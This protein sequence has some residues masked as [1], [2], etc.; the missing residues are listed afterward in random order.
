MSMIKNNQVSEYLATVPAD[1]K[2][3][4]TKVLEIIERHI[5]DEFEQEFHYGMITYV[6]P[7]SKYPAGY[8]DN[9]EQPLPYLSLAARKK[10]ITLSLMSI[11]TDKSIKN[12]FEAAAAQ[13]G[14]R[15]DM[16]K[17]CIYFKNEADIPQK[18]LAQVLKQVSA[19]DYIEFY[20]LARSRKWR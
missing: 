7:L 14:V 1:K 9:P 11:Y 17:S 12:D 19:D 8:L 20:E 3:T 10:Y 15:L 13:E 18:A 6:V 5:P 16:G 2:P 4:L